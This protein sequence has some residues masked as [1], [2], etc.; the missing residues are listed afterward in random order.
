MRSSAQPDGSRRGFCPNGRFRRNRS[1]I[2]S[3]ILR[4]P[5]SRRERSVPSMAKHP[6]RPLRTLVILLALFA[7]LAVFVRWDNTSLRS[8]LFSVSSSRLPA[9]FDGFRIAVL[10]DLHGAEF[11]EGNAELFSA[12]SE[13]QPDLIAFTGDLVDH[14]RGID[15]DAVNRAAAGLAA[16]APVYYVTGNHEWA[17][18]DV[19][20]LKELLSAAGWTVLSNRFVTLERNGDTIAL[21]GIDDPNGYADQKT[22]E[23]L[24]A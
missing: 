23:A 4:R 7:A 24:A 15:W 18:G 1:A 9:G 12:V 22:P 14:Y 16:I 2:F 6:R 19:P 11:C 20:A 17:A 10:S 3:C 5:D 8:E 13:L 21:A